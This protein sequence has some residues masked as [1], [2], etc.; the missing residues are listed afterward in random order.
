[1]NFPLKQ[2]VYTRGVPACNP[3]KSPSILLVAP[4]SIFRIFF[5]GKVPEKCEK[6]KAAR[7]PDASRR[8]MAFPDFSHLFSG[9]VPENKCERS[10]HA[11]RAVCVRVEPLAAIHA[12]SLRASS[13]YVDLI[14]LAVKGPT[15]DQT[16]Q[17]FA[18]ATA[19]KSKARSSA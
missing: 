12:C 13:A 16:A 1:M 5:S 7:A 8:G 18:C 17:L 2:S 15:R 11:T 9:K 10:E 19:Y 4:L 14:P 3:G 6:S